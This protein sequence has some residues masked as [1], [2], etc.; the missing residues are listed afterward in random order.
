MGYMR[1][2]E[3]IPLYELS[4]NKLIFYTAKSA[5]TTNVLSPISDLK[6]ERETLME[7]DL[8]DDHFLNVLKVLAKPDF[9]SHFA[10]AGIEEDHEKFSI[11]GG[12][13][14]KTLYLIFYQ[15]IQNDVKLLSFDSVEELA[16]YVVSRYATMNP[17]KP[18]INM[19]VDMNIDHFIFTLNMIDCIRRRY[20][21]GLLNGQYMPL[22]HL[23]Q[24]AYLEE[25]DFNLNH[26]DVRWLLPSALKLMPKLYHF[27]FEF[28]PEKIHWDDAYKLVSKYQADESDEVLYFLSEDIKKMGLDF[29]HHW[30][31]ALGF[32]IRDIDQ[33]KSHCYLA[34]TATVNHFFELSGERDQGVCH[35]RTLDFKS[36]LDQFE[37]IFQ[38]AV[39]NRWE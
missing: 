33:V 20:L 19:A 39:D 37:S 1:F 22:E 11:Y 27:K 16:T 12:K 7:D 18:L 28:G 26:S 34:P 29:T 2:L 3:D 35:Y 32:Y 15:V 13:V 30:K 5:L 17:E 14:D 38:K 25:L 24:T 36:L 4:F 21:T 23:P 8:P 31:Y 9:A 6:F 10:K